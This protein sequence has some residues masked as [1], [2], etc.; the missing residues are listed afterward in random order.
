MAPFAGDT[1][2]VADGDSGR[3]RVEEQLHGVMGFPTRQSL[4]PYGSTARP[5]LSAGLHAFPSR[6]RPG[7]I[8]PFQALSHQGTAYPRCRPAPLHA[9]SSP[10]G[11]PVLNV[12]LLSR[13][14][15]VTSDPTLALGP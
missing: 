8:P 7:P 6:L 11:L 13:V 10:R 9:M 12:C 5:I 14:T 2:V 1:W 3:Q 15:S 4:Q